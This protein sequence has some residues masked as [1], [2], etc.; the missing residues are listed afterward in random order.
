MKD[1]YFLSRAYVEFGPFPTAE[2]LGFFDRGLLRE[3]DYILGDGTES[4]WLHVSEWVAQQ[5]PPAK[6]TKAVKPPATKAPTAK[7]VPKEE[8]TA[9]AVAT[10]KAPK[11]SK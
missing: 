1:S 5:R 4:Q 8:A 2:M 6:P 11:K 7:K 3:E 9:K 10:K